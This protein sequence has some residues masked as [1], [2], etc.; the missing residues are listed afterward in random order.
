MAALE[1]GELEDGEVPEAGLKEKVKHGSPDEVSHLVGSGSE[2]GRAEVVVDA[3]RPRSPSKKDPTDGDGRSSSREAGHRSERSRSRDRERGRESDRGRGERGVERT[4]RVRE[5]RERQ[6]LQN[7]LERLTSNIT[8]H[9]VRSSWEYTCSDLRSAIKKLER[10]AKIVKRRRSDDIDQY[11]LCHNYATRVHSGIKH[12]VVLC[13][14]G[15][16]RTQNM[17]AARYLMKTTMNYRHDVFSKSQKREVEGWIRESK[18]FRYLIEDRDKRGDTSRRPSGEDGGHSTGGE[19]PK[20]EVGAVHEEVAHNE[21]NGIAKRL[22]EGQNSPVEAPSDPV[23]EVTLGRTTTA[24]EDPMVGEEVGSRHGSDGGSPS[25]PEPESPCPLPEEGLMLT[26]SGGVGGQGDGISSL[27]GSVSEGPVGISMSG[28]AGSVVGATPSYERARNGIAA[29]VS[30]EVGPPLAEGVQSHSAQDEPQ[31]VDAASTCTNV[32][33][34]SSVPAGAGVTSPR[35]DRVPDWELSAE[36]T[37]LGRVPVAS[38]P[39]RQIDGPPEARDLPAGS[40]W[41]SGNKRTYSPGECLLA[42]EERGTDKMGQGKRKRAE[43]PAESVPPFI[44][45]GHDVEAVPQ[46]RT[47]N[48]TPLLPLGPTRPV[49]STPSH[50]PQLGEVGPVGNSSGPPLGMEVKELLRRRRLCLVLDL[51]HTLL[52]SVKFSEVDVNTEL[53]LQQRLKA[54][55]E[56]LPENTRELYRLPALSMWTKLRP[57]VREFL[58]QAQELFELWIHT[59]GNLVYAEAMVQLLDRDGRLFADRI[60]AQGVSVDDAAWANIKRLMQG[61]EGREPVVVIVDDSSAVWP[62]DKRNLFQVERYIYFPQSRQRF[63]MTGESLLEMNRDECPRE[64][65]LMTAFRKLRDVHRLVFENLGSLPEDDTERWDVRDMM[66]RL[67]KQVLLGCHIVFSRLIPLDTSPMKH[68]L[69]LLAESYGAKCH[70]HCNENVTHVV[71]AG[72]GTEKV[73]W[74]IQNGRFVVTP[75]WLE[76]SCLMWRRA[77]EAKFAIAN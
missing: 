49:F 28:A 12:V 69:W 60:L 4:D 39:L 21:E 1:D 51:D 42:E 71:A 26:G 23:L 66:G 22:E 15:Y 20:A 77:T 35:K 54:E 3:E 24:T 62:H 32:P 38:P 14:T 33:V 65:M 48:H 34:P 63:N 72:G 19:E 64:G 56:G 59:N 31:G 44:R 11:P 75:Q 30:S 57:G 17:E 7:E 53:A 25:P 27:A 36:G 5:Q 52:N 2:P 13:G 46:P 74:A 67:R 16:G 73:F 8:F 43:D 47:P 9:S 70:T 29:T 45:R 40:G 10:L 41:L 61:L 37:S 6:T 50:E 58:R 76:C 55:R 18:E 68:V